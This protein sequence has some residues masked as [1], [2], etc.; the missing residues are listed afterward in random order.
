MNLKLSLC[1]ITCST[2]LNAQ[3]IHIQS[4]ATP[5]GISLETYNQL[6]NFRNQSIKSDTIF[7]AKHEE[8]KEK[9]LNLSQTDVA[10][11]AMANTKATEEAN[12]KA[13]SRK[14]A[15]SAKRDFDNKIK[16]A[17]L[18]PPNSSGQKAT[19]RVTLSDSGAVTS[20]IVNASDPDVKASVEQAVR[21]A[22]PYPMPSDPDARREARSFTS[23]FTM[24]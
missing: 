4:T 12:K 22:A 17:W 18:V 19:A 24:K 13:E 15:S 11:K 23:S 8:A 5:E 1:L 3:T 21:S 16:R 6:T 14:T 9:T 20:V 10:V 7:K 2:F